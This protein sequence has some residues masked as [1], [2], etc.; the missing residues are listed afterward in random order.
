MTQYNFVHTVLFLTIQN[1]IMKKTLLFGLLNLLFSMVGISQNQQKLVVEAGKTVKISAKETTL[2]ELIMEDNATIELVGLKN[3]TLNAR[4][5]RIG[6]NCKIIGKG[7]NGKNGRKGRNGN[8]AGGDC[9]RGGNGGNGNHGKTGSSGTDINIYMEILDLGT[10]TIDTR[11][12]KGGNGGN[13]GQ[14]G[15]GGKADVSKNCRGGNGGT[16]GNGGNAGRGGDGGNIV[17]EY[18]FRGKTPLFNSSKNIKNIKTLMGGGKNGRIGKAG[19]GGNGG[20]SVKR[21][22]IKKG[23]GAGGSRGKSGNNPNPGISGK[24]TTNAVDGEDCLDD[25]DRNN[26]AIVVAISESKSGKGDNPVFVEDAKKLVKTLKQNYSFEEVIPYYNISRRELE[27]D[28]LKHLGDYGEE[29][30]IFIYLSGHGINNANF[31]A[32]NTSDDYAM[33]FN[34]IYS[35]VEG[36]NVGRVFLILDA[37]HSGRIF[38]NKHNSIEAYTPH[39]SRLWHPRETCGKK[40]LT[41]VSSGFDDETVSTRDFI[42]ELIHKLASN[43]DKT[44]T[45]ETL[46]YRIKK[47]DFKTQKPVFG[48][49]KT[50]ESNQC[51][52]S[53]FIF[54][55][56]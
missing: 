14:A 48:K 40:A 39:L 8:H 41:V 43:K 26:Y 23:G 3:W 33:P 19:A 20:R 4:T 30:N 7:K 11:G 50:C 35:Y 55:K 15:H 34:A 32:F 52:E 54:F 53:D 16:G 2:N 28:I 13:G 5:A 44:L 10:L 38:D 27:D 56:Q 6:K 22:F 17:F 18:S 47:R 36:A 12:G 21:G 49:S 45:A 9:K 42:E 24:L 37:C 31:P 46:F 51:I 25:V 1:R 29:S